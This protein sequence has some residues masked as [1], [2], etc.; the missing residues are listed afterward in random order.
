MIVIFIVIIIIK[1]CCLHYYINVIFPVIDVCLQVL[2]LLYA[3]IFSL[4]AIVFTSMN[5][6]YALCHRDAK[7]YFVTDLFK[8]LC[9]IFY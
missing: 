6:F 3:K 7:C 8:T 1:L 9:V 5:Q 4:L 2:T